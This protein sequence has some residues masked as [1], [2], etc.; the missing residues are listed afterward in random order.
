MFTINDCQT[1]ATL[2]IEVD[3][4]EQALADLDYLIEDSLKT[5]CDTPQKQQE[6]LMLMKVKN[7]YISAKRAYEIKLLELERKAYENNYNPY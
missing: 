2:I 3:E 7:S 4:L 5:K 6:F 1:L